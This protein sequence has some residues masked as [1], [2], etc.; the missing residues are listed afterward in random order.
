MYKDRAM[1]KMAVSLEEKGEI[2][3]FSADMNVYIQ[4]IDSKEGYSYITPGGNE[5][6]SSH[7][8]VQWA[9]ARFKGIENI[10]RWE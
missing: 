5:F 3:F 1:D 7:E 8:A 10:G 6:D 2:K 9:I 4:S